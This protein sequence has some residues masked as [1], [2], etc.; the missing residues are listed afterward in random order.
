[1]SVSLRFKQRGL[2][3]SAAS[4][5]PPLEHLVSARCGGCHL[6]CRRHNSVLME[7][8]PGKASLSLELLPEFGDAF[9]CPVPHVRRPTSR[10]LSCLE[11]AGAFQL[12]GGRHGRYWLSP[13]D[14]LDREE[15]ILASA[16]RKGSGLKTSRGES[17]TVRFSADLKRSC[18]T[19]TPCLT[20]SFHQYDFNVDQK[21]GLT[22]FPI[23][24]FFLWRLVLLEE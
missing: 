24:Y 3:V 8:A 20:L 7:E 19:T 18:N 15:G 17:G 21:R 1:M 12:D 2:N 10:R 13:C 23:P 4:T 22:P 5:A 6:H 11:H 9:G 16:D 14:Q